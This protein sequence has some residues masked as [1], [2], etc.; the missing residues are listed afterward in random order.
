M[1]KTRF[2]KSLMENEEGTNHLWIQISPLG[3]VK[4]PRVQILLPAGLHRLNNLS[5]YPETTTQE[6]ELSNPLLTSNVV[7][8]LFTRD[9]IRSGE[10]TII[11]ALSY[12]QSEGKLNR[13]EHFVP[14]NVVSEDEIDSLFVDEEAVHF[15][16]E[17]VKPQTDA[18]KQVYDHTQNKVL[19]LGPNKYAGLEK[20]YRIEGDL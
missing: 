19:R 15:I 14:L 10:I 17:L 1:I 9:A 5:G 20:K 13:I 7:I 12:K 6:I 4:E 8:E 16:K 2:T 18:D 11:V 3:P